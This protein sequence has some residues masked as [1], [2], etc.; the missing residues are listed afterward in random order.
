SGAGTGAIYLLRWFWWR[1]NAWTEVVAMVV[2]TINAIVLVAIMNYELI[3]LRYI[4]EAGKVIIDQN[5]MNMLIAV[6]VTTIAW[7]ITTLVTKPESD[8]VLRAFVKQCHPGGPGWAKVVAKAKTEGLTIDKNDGQAWEMPV[9][10]LCVFLGCVGVYSSLFA[11]GN[12]LYGQYTY[13]SVLAVIAIA[14]LFGL[15]K[16]FGKLKTD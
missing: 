13:G 1:I 8:E 16:S 14:S 12:F 3:D 5:T 4:N 6:L 11:I 2:A 7:I 9:Q 10:I 15:F